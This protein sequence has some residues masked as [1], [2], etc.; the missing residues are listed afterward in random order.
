MSD[1]RKFINYL[2]VVARVGAAAFKDEFVTNL[3]WRERWILEE[4]GLFGTPET[5]LNPAKDPKGPF[6]SLPEL[7]AARAKLAYFDWQRNRI[8]DW[9]VTHGVQ[10]FARNGLKST[11]LNS[12]RRLL[13]P[14]PKPP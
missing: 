9:L 11:K 5:F 13:T 1:A 4:T 8:S 12:K 14:F 7:P 2:E 3:T 10:S 6:A